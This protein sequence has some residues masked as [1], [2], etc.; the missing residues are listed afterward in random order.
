MP[1]AVGIFFA[2][3]FS[4]LRMHD[5]AGA[6]ATAPE[7]TC[8]WQGSEAQVEPGLDAVVADAFGDLAIAEVPRS[9]APESFRPIPAPSARASRA[10]GTPWPEGGRHWQSHA[11]ASCHQGPS[12]SPT[13]QQ[14]QNRSQHADP[15]AARPTF[16]R[17]AAR[18]IAL[19][20]DYRACFSAQRCK[21]SLYG[22]SDLHCTAA[23]PIPFSHQSSPEHNSINSVT[24]YDQIMNVNRSVS[25]SNSCE[26]HSQRVTSVRPCADQTV[27]WRASARSI[28]CGRAIDLCNNITYQGSHPMRLP[29]PCPKPA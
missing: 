14:V 26:P 2:C 23:K 3:H 19:R 6:V 17:P 27:R 4:V 25:Q 10:S 24:I 28:E 11:L 9:A 7:G 15:K 21:G 16:A 18:L 22:R 5:E 8:R 13:C 29:P 12:L 1:A 20:R